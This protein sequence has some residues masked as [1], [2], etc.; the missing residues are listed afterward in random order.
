MPP[1]FGGTLNYVD[2][3]G[4]KALVENWQKAREQLAKIHNIE[5]SVNLKTEHVDP[6][7]LS[8]LRA[9]GSKLSGGLEKV[10]D[11]HETMGDV[12]KSVAKGDKLRAGDT[13][14]GNAVV[15]ALRGAAGA[16]T[17]AGAGAAAGST[18]GPVG[19]AAGGLAGLVTP[20]AARKIMSSGVAKPRVPLSTQ[21]ANIDPRTAAAVA[22]AAAGRTSSPL[23]PPMQ[24]AK[25]R[26]TL[27]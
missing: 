20:L 13:A 23:P 7:K 3:T 22:A 1:K 19:A 25:D 4:R 14:V 11:A 6:A 5:E 2:N 18:F 27:E 16:V 8:K 15:K 17:G 21:A 24:P 10:A 9:Q 26:L 12:V